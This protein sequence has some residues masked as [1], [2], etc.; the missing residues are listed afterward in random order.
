MGG[1]GRKSRVGRDASRG[2]GPSGRFSLFF[3]CGFD[4][5]LFWAHLDLVVT[6]SDGD[7]MEMGLFVMGAG[8][9]HEDAIEEMW[10]NE[11]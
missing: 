9:R 6:D 8:R 3:S 7:N 11:V 1:Q 2:L 10:G 5:F 4:A